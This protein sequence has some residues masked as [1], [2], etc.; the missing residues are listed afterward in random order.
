MSVNLNDPVRAYLSS[1]A[2][3]KIDARRLGFR[4]R[5]LEAQA[6]RITTTITGM[7]GGGG[8]DKERLLVELADMRA[9]S[10]AARIKAEK[11]E[12]E[13]AAFINE[14]SDRVSRM[15]LKLRYCECLEWETTKRHRRSV[16]GELSKV[17]LCIGLRQ[18]YRLHG[19][20]LNEARELYKEKN[21]D[22]KRN[23]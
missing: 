4:V 16:I 19:K 1:V 10:E 6:T 22:K 2:E 11:Q 14:L 23:P 5:R 3:A 18:L 20:A 8:G 9:K 12:E 13:V 21:Y 7:P 17:G 15:I